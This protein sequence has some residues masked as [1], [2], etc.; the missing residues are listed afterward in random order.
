[1][2]CLRG[3]WCSCGA[4]LHTPGA[5]PARLTHCAAP[6][7][8]GPQVQGIQEERQGCEG[9]VSQMG[10]RTQQLQ[11][12]LADNERKV[13]AAAGGQ[14]DVDKVLVPADELTKQELQVSLRGKPAAAGCKRALLLAAWCC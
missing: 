3:S 10:Q 7:A 8:P 9:L 1:M 11:G 2:C 6:C 5:T 12:W 13:A 14:L 4:L